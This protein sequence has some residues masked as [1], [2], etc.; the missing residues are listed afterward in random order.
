MSLSKTVAF[1]FL[2][3]ALLLGFLF[4]RA[5]APVAPV[6]PV[7]PT[8]RVDP[9]SAWTCAMHPQVRLP[10]PGPCPICFMD[11]IPVSAAD[12][13]LGP[14]G[15]MI[16][17]M[18]KA[19]AEI[20][21]APVERRAVEHEV[22]MVGKV[23]FDETRLAHIT[24]RVGGRLDRLFV[25]YTGVTVRKG[26]H[27]VEIY[28][29]ELY[30]AQR[31]L[32]Q[33]I[34][35]TKRMGPDSLPVLREASEKTIAS[36]RER[37]RLFGLTPGQIDEIAD[38]GEV[39]EH[40]TLLA[41]SGGVVVHKNATKGMY[42]DEGTLIYTIADL[43]KVWV[44]LD[45]YESDLAWLAYGQNV[46]F[47]V[48]AYP[49][50]PFNGRVAF[51]DPVLDDQSRTVKVRLNVA[52]PEGKLKPDMFVSAIARAVLTP[53][54]HV[55]DRDVAGKWMCPMHPEVLSD[56]PGT[57][58]ECGMD[59]MPTSELGFVAADTDQELPLVIPATAPLITG[60]RAVVYVQVPDAEN[61]T[62]IGR[63]VQLGPRA[64]DY[65]V[66]KSGLQLGEEVVVNGN[67][68]LDSE[69]Q[70][71]AEPSMMNPEGGTPP[72]GHRHGGAMPGMSAAGAAPGP[73]RLTAGPAFRDGL[74]TVLD[75]YLAVHDALARDD[76][77]GARQ[78]A[79]RMSA[80]CTA[81]DTNGL[82][83]EGVTA[84][85][86][87]GAE[88]RAAIA[89]LHGAADIEA[90]RAVLPR[91]T[92]ATA[93]LLDGYGYR[94]GTEPARIFHCPMALDGAGADWLQVA[95]QVANP[96]FG[97]AMLRCGTGQRT[98]RMEP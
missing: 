45:A 58:P 9:G 8:G 14:R 91:L 3:L 86:N 29:P 34:E 30:V 39:D 54:G 16:S 77:G 63:E 35:T 71:R 1:L 96:Y 74:G 32:L 98:L 61:P 90:R 50:E 38:R 65:Y 17:D 44:L 41:P 37:L 68:K 75:A 55:V 23:A 42:V 13:G 72:P 73:R 56:G 22:R 69:L 19:L 81:L 85:A 79:E 52:N 89:E 2:A 6:A 51:I 46:Q 4:G 20:E 5:L 15:L 92:A 27:M 80:A 70:I 26:D 88:L 10:E 94:H 59:L 57:C 33:A 28:S 53:H 43:S 66:V 12:S 48:H 84:W 18:A 40:V 97:E 60:K 21:T 64:G 95:D 49:G 47:E 62:F 11:L 83:G 87:L 76:D 67:F 82:E 25:D 36:A 78:A 93:A 24:A 31:D 7:L